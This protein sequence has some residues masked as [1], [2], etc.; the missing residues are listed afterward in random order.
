MIPAVPQW[1]DKSNPGD[2]RSGG[3]VLGGSKKGLVMCTL[4]GGAINGDPNHFFVCHQGF[5]YDV[6]PPAQGEL[7]LVCRLSHKE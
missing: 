4:F 2:L 7:A 6:V 3:E 1:G 5:I